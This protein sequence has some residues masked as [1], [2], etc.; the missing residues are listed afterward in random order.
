MPGSDGPAER[1]SASLRATF[2]P[3]N[4]LR[5]LCYSSFKGRL[6]N[7]APRL[8]GETRLLLCALRR[9]S[10]RPPSKH[11]PRRLASRPVVG[12][13]QAV[14][15][16][17]APCS[18]VPRMRAG[19]TAFMERKTERNEKEEREEG[20]ISFVCHSRRKTG[21]ATSARAGRGSRTAAFPVPRLLPGL[22]FCSVFLPDFSESSH[23]RLLE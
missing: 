15:S 12:G 16:L 17:P 14:S 5:C 6:G 9:R 21:F 22:S 19:S 7:L 3:L 8:R 4:A 1:A 2:L 18:L 10:V 13:R 11:R 23:V 20:R